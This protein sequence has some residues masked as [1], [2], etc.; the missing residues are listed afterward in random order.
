MPKRVGQTREIPARRRTAARSLIGIAILAALIYSPAAGAAPGDISTYAGRGT[1]G[2]SGDGGPARKAK[3]DAPAGLALSSGNLYVADFKQGRVRRVS[4][5]GRI[6][7]VAGTHTRGFSG[8]GGPGTKAKLNR[9]IGLAVDVTPPDRAD[10]IGRLLD[11]LE[12]GVEPLPYSLATVLGHL[13]TDK[14]HAGGRLRWVLPTADG[15]TIRDDIDAATVERAAAGLL[16]APS[17]VRP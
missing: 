10:R 2:F 16:V 3:L 17:E 11:R 15:V 1:A 12:L 13:A 4:R 8:D 7:T 14:K 5:S 9:P 6:T